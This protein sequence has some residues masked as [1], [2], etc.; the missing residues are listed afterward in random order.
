VSKGQSLEKVRFG[1]D[2]D[3]RDA[4]GRERGEVC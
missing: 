2:L 3:M 1:Q 4:E